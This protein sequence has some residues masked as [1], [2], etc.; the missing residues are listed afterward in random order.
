MKL[1][2]RANDLQDCAALS[3]YLAER[4]ARAYGRTVRHLAHLALNEVHY[5]S[6]VGTLL[7]DVKFVA[8]AKQPRIRVTILPNTKLDLAIRSIVSD[9]GRGGS[10]VLLAL[11]TVGWR[12]FANT[13]QSV[14]PQPMELPASPRSTDQHEVSSPTIVAATEDRSINYDN[15]QLRSLIKGL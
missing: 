5:K 7:L 2:I 9:T 6:L 3:A 11:V 4:D 1:S 8:S 13:R 10:E 12:T 15:L 14:A